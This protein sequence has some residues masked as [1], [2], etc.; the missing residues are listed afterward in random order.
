MKQLVMILCVLLASTVQAKNY[1]ISAKGL[2]ANTGLSPTSAWQTI[3]KLNASFGIIAAGDSILFKSGETFYG[4]IVVGKS[5]TSS[6]P[7]VFG[8]YG[9]GAKPVITGFT[10]PTAWTNMGGGIWKVNL[11]NATKNLIILTINDQYQR[12]GRYPNFDAPNGGYLTYQ[13]SGSSAISD[14][15]LPSTPNWTGADVVIRKYAF[16]LDVC[17][18]TNHSGGTISYTNST[19]Y[20]GQNNYGYFIQNDIKTLDQFGEWYLDKTT[21]D[22]SVF[23]GSNSP[24]SYQVKAGTID[25]LFCV[26]DGGLAATGRVA[27]SNITVTNLA[28][29]GANKFGFYSFNGKNIT[30]RNCSFNNNYN[31]LYSWNVPNAV[32]DNNIISNTLNNGIQEYGQVSS[33]TVITNNTVKNCGL[34]AGMGESGDGTYCGIC[35]NGNNANLLNNRID[36][37]GFNALQ[38][39]GSNIAVKFNYITNFCAVKDDGGGIYTWG[40]TSQTNRVVQSNIVI[41]GI[42]APLGRYEKDGRTNPIYMDGGTRHVVIMDNT[43][44]VT[45]GAGLLTNTGV[46]I[47]VFRNTFYKVP[48]GLLAQR[49]PNNAADPSGYVRNYKI[50]GNIFYPTASN[51]SYWNG[52]L[53]EPVPMDIQADMRAIGTFDSNYYRKDILQP[54]HYF[55]HLTAGGTYV[56]PPVL[57]AQGW[58]SYMNQDANSKEIATIPNYSVTGVV[59]AN[60]VKNGAFASNITNFFSSSGSAGVTVAWDG[61][62]KITGAGSI[63]IAPSTPSYNYTLLYQSVGTVSAGKSYLL[64]FKSLGS[65][66]SGILKAYVRQT[67]SPY[68]ALVPEQFGYTT[69]SMTQH[70]FLISMPVSASDASLM[71]EVEQSTGTTYLDDIEFYEVTATLN[72][73]ST[74]VRFEFNA[75][76]ESKTISLDAKYV[77]VDSTVY[78]GSITLAPFTSAILFKAGPSSTTLKA[79]AGTDISLT[80]P[81]NSTVLKGSAVG[82]I[83]SYTWSKIAG[84]D[85]FTI[86]TPDN[87]STSISNLSPGSYTF[88]LKVMNSAGD[89]ALALV[90]VNLAGT[91]PVTLI[92]FTAK[93]SNEKTV[94]LQWQVSSEINVSHYTIERSSN[95]QDF[96]NV[97]DL[98][99]NNLANIQ[100]N[101]NFSDNFPLQGVN[102]YRLVMID[103]DG[104]FKYSKTVSAS[105]SGVASFKLLNVVLSTTDQNF[106]VMLNSNYRQPMQVVLV[107]ASGRIIY[108]KQLQIEKGFNKIENKIPAIGTGVYYAKIFSNEQVINKT[109]LSVH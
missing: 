70:E 80:L 39:F 101:Y 47:S 88:Q 49:F 72:D 20:S 59:S 57:D 107:D 68:A 22:L 34:F 106:K 2:D 52:Q 50:A 33:P 69:T 82:T 15:S 3:A 65:A 12:L 14:N 29:E 95:G 100:I 58:K 35:Q 55:Y 30:V 42:G 71:V 102:Y 96:E 93:A 40:D 76:I 98:K 24:S 105:V 89:S 51:I 103:N 64:R 48:V 5:G 19:N 73:A 1:Y 60:I 46:D 83:T 11:P 36:S 94:A 18:I 26:G 21:K 99:S 75:S 13:A 67:A 38:F 62:S 66:P 41:G 81:T 84:P 61:T 77:S 32:C 44:S 56:D 108:T 10:A 16:I 85:Q 25:T 8:S 63:R 97:G 28:F 9:T 6:L 92:D 87:P 43:V 90:N 91:L 53:N 31:G 104:S 54:F 4:S 27:Q 109:L 23:F 45:D 37:V 86:A 79:D 78:D 74:M 7:I 17:K